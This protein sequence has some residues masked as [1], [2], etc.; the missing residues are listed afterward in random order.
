[1]AVPYEYSGT[2]DVL[3]KVLRNDGPLGLFRG[4]EAKLWQTG[5]RAQKFCKNNHNF[6]RI[7][8]CIFNRTDFL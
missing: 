8:R 5:T 3:L 1:M 7:L 2:V 6:R 4:C